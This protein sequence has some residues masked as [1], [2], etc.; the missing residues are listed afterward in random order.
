MSNPFDA[1]EFAPVVFYFAYRLDDYRATRWHT[2]GPYVSQAAAM[3][4]ARQLQSQGFV[5][6]EVYSR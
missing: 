6:G 4:D 3:S 5:T 1:V 2:S